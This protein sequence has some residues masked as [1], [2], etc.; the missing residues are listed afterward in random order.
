MARG[1]VFQEIRSGAGFNIGHFGKE[2]LVGLPQNKSEEIE[3][4]LGEVGLKVLW[5][6]VDVVGVSA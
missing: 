5:Y 3:H 2:M 6:V 4:V 1:T